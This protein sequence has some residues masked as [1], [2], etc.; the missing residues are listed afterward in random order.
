[1]LYVCGYVWLTEAD[2]KRIFPQGPLR[3]QQMYNIIL[4]SL[5]AL[6]LIK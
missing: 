1:M 5:I 3:L 4:S 2:L 6:L